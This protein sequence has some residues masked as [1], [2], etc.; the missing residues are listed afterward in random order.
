MIYKKKTRAKSSYL[1]HRVV[2]MYTSFYVER[3]TLVIEDDA[4]AWDIRKYED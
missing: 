4:A 1:L 2:A 3:L